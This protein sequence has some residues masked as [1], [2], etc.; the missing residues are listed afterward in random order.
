MKPLRWAISNV[1]KPFSVKLMKN[2]S[3]FNVARKVS[4]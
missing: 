3:F 2:N 1:E 4:D